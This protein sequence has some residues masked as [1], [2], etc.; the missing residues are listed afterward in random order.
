VLAVI[1]AACEATESPVAPPGGGEEG[2]ASPAAALSVQASTDQ[3]CGEI[4]PT[5]FVNA[6]APAG[7]VD[8]SL[9]SEWKTQSGSNWFEL[10]IDAYPDRSPVDVLTAGPVA[11]DVGLGGIRGDEPGA[12]VF[13]GAFSSGGGTYGTVFGGALIS[14][15]A[16]WG[17]EYAHSQ[18]TFDFSEPVFGFGAWVFDDAGRTSQSFRLLARLSDGSQVTSP[19]LESGNGVAHRVEGFLGVT[20]AFGIQSVAIEVIDEFGRAVVF[21]T[22]HLHLSPLQCTTLD[23]VEAILNEV[24][25]LL[26]NGSLDEGNSNALQATL[27]GI[28]KSIASDRPNAVVRIQ[29]FIHNVEGFVNGG[30]LSG[31]DGDL[32]IS[33]AQVLVGRLDK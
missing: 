1:A 4:N 2:S 25:G 28:E 31:A 11:I 26:S 29:A 33:A 15:Y 21:E 27:D 19:V 16:G 7:V 20:N 9:D 5:F 6:A 18:I 12:L 13:H 32:L 3:R 30:I 8:P 23:Q 17:N 24:A 10:D 22:D 14:L